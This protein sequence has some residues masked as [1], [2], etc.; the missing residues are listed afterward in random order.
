MASALIIAILS[1]AS[2]IGANAASLPLQRCLLDPADVNS[3][4]YFV[5]LEIGSRSYRLLVDSG[6]ADLWIRHPSAQPD[7][8]D[9]LSLPE[10]DRP[11]LPSLTEAELYKFSA[12]ALT[13]HH[14]WQGNY[15]AGSYAGYKVRDHIRVPLSDGLPPLVLENQPF[16]LVILEHT[17]HALPLD[18][19]IGIAFNPLYPRL[20]PFPHPVGTSVV[21]ADAVAFDLRSIWRNIAAAAVNTGNKE[22]EGEVNQTAPIIASNCS[23]AIKLSIPVRSGGGEA[24]VD[25]DSH[26]GNSGDTD[27][28]QRTKQKPV[29][30]VDCLPGNEQSVMAKNS[31]S[32]TTTPDYFASG[33]YDQEESAWWIE[34]ASVSWIR[35]SKNHRRSTDNNNKNNNNK[36]T[37]DSISTI[38]ALLD[39]GSPLMQLDSQSY[40][41]LLEW[42]EVHERRCNRQGVYP[43]RMV[44]PVDA[45]LPTLDFQ[46][47]NQDRRIL[48]ISPD[49]Y[50]QVD[51]DGLLRLAAQV[52]PWA[53]HGVSPSSDRVWILGISFLAGFNA[54]EFDADR[55]QVRFEPSI[56]S[57]SVRQS[58]FSNQPPS[59]GDTADMVMPRSMMILVC[60]IVGVAL[61]LFNYALCG[62]ACRFVRSNYWLKSDEERPLLNDNYNNNAGRSSNR[63]VGCFD[64]AVN[65]TVGDN[66]VP[67]V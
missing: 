53:E 34:L 8:G 11:S 31:I 38:K 35:N 30:V 23:L 63:D 54:I 12:T 52:N 47:H 51:T 21:A 58:D 27:G 36:K 1:S 10:W 26:G 14:T 5:E 4:A 9:I 16:A 39:S 43:P 18:G 37:H 6:S 33:D 64:S 57:S 67:P 2:G 40:E 13:E 46:L 42:L 48:T 66:V 55:M 62:N 7:N 19:I 44:C 50:M 15:G 45:H 3:E 29:V 17:Q 60:L 61:C 22:E 20:P 65:D 24:N 32:V 25:S 49:A 28:A 59:A 41:E 56:S